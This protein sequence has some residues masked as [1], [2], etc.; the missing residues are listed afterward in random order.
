MSSSAL[1]LKSGYNSNAN[2][3]T[4]TLSS[5]LAK[6]VESR[7]QWTKG[8]WLM[9]ILI[10]LEVIL[11]VVTQIMFVHSYHRV[12]E[13][14]ASHE[15][16]EQRTTGAPE[17]GN[18]TPTRIPNDE[19]SYVSIQQVTN[20]AK[21]DGSC[22]N[23]TVMAPITPDR[24]TRLP[25]YLGTIANNTRLPCEIVFSLS[26]YNSSVL[27]I[28]FEKHTPEKLKDFTNIVVIMTNK[29]QLA[30][31]NRNAIA[32]VAT[33]EILASFDSDDIAS[34]IWIESVEKVM[35]NHAKYDWMLFKWFWCEDGKPSARFPPPEYRVPVL[36]DLLSINSIFPDS[37]IKT[38][39][40]A[41][42]WACCSRDGRPPWA[43]GYIVARRHVWDRFRQDSRVHGEDSQFVG[44]LLLNNVSG[45]YVNQQ[46]LG[47]CHEPYGRYDRWTKRRLLPWRRLAA[48]MEESRKNA[49]LLM[50]TP[51]IARSMIV[52][53]NVVSL[54]ALGNL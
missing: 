14:Q 29:K 37:A 43:N 13:Q 6:K 16:Q 42:M 1:L 22:A 9:R 5:P 48:K 54:A 25:T 45:V 21:R 17:T 34:P 15:S 53:S 52:D 38:R 8:R 40:D 50:R 20:G 4:P 32:K 44:D 19:Y 2:N 12:S 30:G 47:Y 51:T 23:V 24:L 7:R 3:C 18:K 10:A 46:L 33:M 35:K 49:T 31:Q 11:Y 26:S 41:L 39:R 36:R 28:E 27:P